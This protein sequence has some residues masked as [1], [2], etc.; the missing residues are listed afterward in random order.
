[1]QSATMESTLNDE[2]FAVMHVTGE[3]DLDTQDTFEAE[4]ADRLKGGSVVIDLSGLE[5]LAISSLRSL[6]ACEQTAVLDGR[7]VVYAGAPMQA[8]RLLAVSGLDGVLSVGLDLAEA[9]ELVRR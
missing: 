2:P 6:L 9:R 3:L 5:F 7:R 1:M 8:L 4:V